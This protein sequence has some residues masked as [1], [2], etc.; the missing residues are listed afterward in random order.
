MKAAR[1]QFR[2]KAGLILD[3]SMIPAPLENK[4]YSQVKTLS[5]ATYAC[6]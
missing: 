1:E 4:T 3:E 2:K 6:G 5:I